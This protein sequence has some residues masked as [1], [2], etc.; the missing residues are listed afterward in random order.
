MSRRTS[1]EPISHRLQRSSSSFVNPSPPTRQNAGSR[2]LAGASSTQ[3]SPR[4]TAQRRD[5]V[6]SVLERLP[7]PPPSDKANQWRQKH[8]SFAMSASLFVFS[9]AFGVELFSDLNM[10]LEVCFW[11][12]GSF[13]HWITYYVSFPLFVHVLNFGSLW[14]DVAWVM[15][16]ADFVLLYIWDKFL[17]CFFFWNKPRNFHFLL[18]I[19][20]FV[21]FTLSSLDY[22]LFCCG[23][24]HP[25]ACA[26]SYGI[27]LNRLLTY[28][29][30]HDA[31]VT[32]TSAQL[33]PSPVTRWR[34]LDDH[35]RALPSSLG[36]GVRTPF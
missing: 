14:Y 24:Y 36:L 7:V 5:R 15:E 2:N 13:V 10:L 35:C 8:V 32:L 18:E 22:R 4:M 33:D 31:Q 16:E 17:W 26:L 12:T 34:H 11:S 3:A 20:L 6:L 19:H 29:A 21:Y 30:Y 27:S 23:K 9:L 1:N 28:Y 25:S